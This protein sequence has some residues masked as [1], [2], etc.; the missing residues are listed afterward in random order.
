MLP[1]V[2][3]GAGVRVDEAQ[4]VAWGREFA[5]RLKA[6]VAVA[7][8]AREHLQYAWLPC[9]EAA[10]KCFSWSNRDAI[11]CLPERAA[12]RRG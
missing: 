10:A 7:L 1:S 5:S 3:D 9:A 6:P 4:L 2:E 12:R 8:D 11:R